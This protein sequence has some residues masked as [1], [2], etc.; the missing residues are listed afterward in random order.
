MQTPSEA[1][2][3]WLRMAEQ[4]ELPRKESEWYATGSNHEPLVRRPPMPP[5]DDWLWNVPSPRVR[6]V[7]IAGPPWHRTLATWVVLVIGLHVGIIAA[8]AAY[9]GRRAIFVALVFLSCTAAAMVRAYAG[10]YARY[11]EARRRCWI[12]L[13]DRLARSGTRPQ[14]MAWLRERVGDETV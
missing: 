13:R 7:R 1:E 3:E 6:G 11:V 2:N 14:T 10:L 5:G 12:T 8:V 9:G 4:R